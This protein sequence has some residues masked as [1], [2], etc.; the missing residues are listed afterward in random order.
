MKRLIGNGFIVAKTA[1]LQLEYEKVEKLDSEKPNSASILKTIL[2]PLLLEKIDTYNGSF[3]AVGSYWDGDDQSE[4][5]INDGIW[6]SGDETFEE[7]V[8]QVKKDDVLILKSTYVGKGARAIS[9]KV[10]RKS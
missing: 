9:S 5:F 2:I 10:F 8:N 3:Y 6:E 1:E 4:R 7:V